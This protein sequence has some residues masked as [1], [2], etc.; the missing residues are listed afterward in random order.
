MIGTEGST[1]SFSA[2]ACITDLWPD[3]FL[4]KTNTATAAVSP[5]ALPAHPSLAPTHI[6]PP[7]LRPEETDTSTRTAHHLAVAAR[8]C[9]FAVAHEV[10]HPFD[11]EMEETATEEEVA[12]HHPRPEEVASCAT[13]AFVR[14]NNRAPTETPSLT[15]PARRCA[16]PVTAR[17]F[18]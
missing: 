14:I 6:A 10:L 11:H 8:P 16:L 1:P 7:A 4:A 12:V 2:L 18:R 5:I 17:H 3:L 9:P 13:T 15:T